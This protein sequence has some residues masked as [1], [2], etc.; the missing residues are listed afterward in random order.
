ML[1]AEVERLEAE[2]AALRERVSALSRR[3]AACGG[4]FPSPGSGA[5]LAG[6]ALPS[7]AGLQHLSW[8]PVTL[9]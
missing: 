3:H 6:A 1:E 5:R 4:A 9:A 8:Q 7:S 2:V